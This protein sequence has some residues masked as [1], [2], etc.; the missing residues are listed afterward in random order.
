M[1]ITTTQVTEDEWIKDS[2]TVRVVC[3]LSLWDRLKVLVSGRVNVQVFTDV[4]QEINRCRTS[5][6][7]WWVGR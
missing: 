7:H 3:G 6:I 2:I 1:T 5:R 4:D